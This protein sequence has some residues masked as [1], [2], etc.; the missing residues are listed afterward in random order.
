VLSSQASMAVL[1]EWRKRYGVKLVK[2]AIAVWL[3]FLALP[4]PLASA[5]EVA[6]NVS[7]LAPRV[8]ASSDRGAWQHSPEALRA[9]SEKRAGIAMLASGALVGA[10]AL[11]LGSLSPCAK[12]A[13][14]SCFDDAK[15]RSLWVMSVPA[16][17]LISAG[18]A[19]LIHGVIRWRRIRPHE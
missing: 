14:N 9:R 13:G 3:A 18:T 7:A 5:T 16:L 1:G 2:P 11:I 10:G 19:S 12:W 15:R 6:V 8:V 17:A 4:Q